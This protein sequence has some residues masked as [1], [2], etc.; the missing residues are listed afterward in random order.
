MAQSMPKKNKKVKKHPKF[1]LGFKIFILITLLAILTGGI[2]FYVKYGK[3]LIR[4]RNSAVDLVN[5]STQDTFMDS[6]TSIAYNYKGKQMC[7]LKGDKDSYYMSIKEI[8]EYVK[9]AFIVTEDKKF[10]EHNGID[11][12]GI[13]RAVWTQIKN[14]GQITQGASTITQQLARGTFLTTEKTYERKIKE[15]FLAQE[16]EK[17]YT[18]DQIFEFY[19]NSIY[20]SN[21]YYG[22]EAAAKGYFS[23]S[24]KELSL[25]QLV[26]LCA[27]PNNPSLYNPETHMD[28]T[29]SRRDRILAQML[30]D[31][32]I[33]QAEHDLATAE[34]IKLKQ[35]TPKKRNYVQ[36]FVMYC[37]TKKV[38][39]LNGFK[40]MYGFD[41][42][43]E[44]NLYEERYKEAYDNAQKQVLNK[45]YRI[46]TSI[47]LKK[48]KALQKAI[49]DNLKDFKEKGTDGT[50][51]MQ[52]A[53]VC[54]DNSTGRV[55]AAVGGRSQN[56]TGYTLNRSFQSFRQPGSSIKPVIVYTPSL[57]RD[58]TPDSTVH[59]FQFKGG[60]ANSDGSYAGY[61]SLRYAVEKSKNTVAWQLFDK[62]TPEVGLQYLLDMH[63]S[64]IVKSDYYN[65][66]SLGGLTYGCSALEMA[67]AYA[68]IENN[69][70]YRE[71][72]CIVKITD[73]E[74]N[75]IVKDK[76]EEKYIYDSVAANE[77]VEIMKG[78]LTRGTGVGLSLDNGMIAAGKTGTTNDKKDGWFC[79]FTPY[80]TTAVWIG[81]DTPVAI[82]SLT[83]ASYPGHTWQAF[84]NAIHQGLEVIPFQYDES[85]GKSKKKSSSSYS[86]YSQRSNSNYSNRSDDS[87]DD[88]DDEG[89]SEEPKPEKKKVTPAKKKQDNQVAE[90]DP[91]AGQDPAPVADPANNPPANNQNN[92]SNNNSNNNNSNKSNTNVDDGNSTSNDNTQYKEDDTTYSDDEGG[93]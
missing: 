41:S 17:K 14:R 44:K 5:K 33:S 53:A 24:C 13:V 42:E 16:M 58:Y 68:T 74:G 83:G 28:N 9:N 73:S 36:T 65:A 19:L 4:Y 89:D 25:S 92:N 43:E 37:A 82:D 38:M 49:N 86:G 52:G 3:D 39:E 11:A 8:P 84:M 31:G 91:N 34:K 27:I 57:E 30:T 79:G 93:E 15:I 64:K 59:D 87:D 1:W 80:Y 10:Y 18:K 71:P 48:Q 85:D 78:V 72:T 6:E 88:E 55:V 12:G 23:K 69:G 45:G 40:F 35:T 76:V 63:F 32:V 60:P 75:E 2:I 21:G 7:V 66:A 22:I 81:C 70:K 46:Y 56:T 50:Y 26:F 61:I 29:I 20:F 67:S 62:L 51:K 90:P 54:V 47:D 77:M